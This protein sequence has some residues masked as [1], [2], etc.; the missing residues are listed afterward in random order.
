MTSSDELKALCD[1]AKARGADISIS[2]DSQAWIKEGRSIIDQVVVHSGIPGIG[3]HPMGAVAA[4]ERLRDAKEKGLLDPVVV[5]AE[6]SAMPRPMPEGM[7]DPMPEVHATFSDGQRLKIF[8]FYPDE[9]QFE[10]HEFVGLTYREARQL[11][12]TKDSCFL[13]LQ[14]HVERQRE[15]RGV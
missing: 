2:F 1:L 7:M 8:E 10:P 11:R 14:G 13:A 15:G 9:L 5:S 12:I 3:P 6:I 4:A